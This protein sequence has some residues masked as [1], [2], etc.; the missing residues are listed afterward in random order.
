MRE[1]DSAG[2]YPSEYRDNPLIEACGPALSKLEI[3]KRLVH[4]PPLP[5]ASV[6]LPREA[7][8][9]HVA[10]T[11]RLHIPTETGIRLTQ[12]ID[13]MIRQGYVHRN[14]K[15]PNTW[16]RIYSQIG[17][18]ADFSPLQLAATVTGLAGMGKSTAIER[19]LQL[20]PQVVQHESFPG[21]VGPVQQLLWVKIDVPSSG[22]IRDLVESL[23][24]ATDAA[25][26]TRFADDLVARRGAN[27]ASLAHRWLQKI[28]CHFPGVIVLDEVQNLFKIA[29]KAVREAA[30]RRPGGSQP[31]LH[32]ADDE[33]LKLLLTITNTSKIPTCWRRPKI[34]PLLRVVPTE[35]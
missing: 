27:G 15:S 1:F 18:E 30:A 7:L 10:S 11:R 12:T 6:N 2:G 8:Q 14:P 35:N 13:L 29:R 20:Y 31:T 17:S 22:K 34:E 32:I 9:H 21:L 33:A 23:A 4:F 19:A 5:P 25:L 24:R 16:R 28:S 3:A 26:N